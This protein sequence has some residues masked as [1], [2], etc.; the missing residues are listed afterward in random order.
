[1]RV[2]ILLRDLGRSKK[3][4]ISSLFD[5]MRLNNWF[6]G[7]E[8]GLSKTEILLLSSREDTMPYFNRLKRI[9][10]HVVQR[11]MVGGASQ[12]KP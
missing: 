1:M 10:F 8:L 12:P 2:A 4:G 6:G 9:H 11:L 7:F 5:V 3:A